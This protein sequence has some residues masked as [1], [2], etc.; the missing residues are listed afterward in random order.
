AAPLKTRRAEGHRGGCPSPCRDHRGPQADAS[1]SSGKLSE[2]DHRIMRPPLR[3]IDTVKVEILP[4]APPAQGQIR[5]RLK[6]RE[7]HADAV[8]LTTLL[9]LDPLIGSPRKAHVHQLVPVPS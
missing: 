3:D 2:H 4:L 1:S 5:A 9:M 6:W 8:R 7:S